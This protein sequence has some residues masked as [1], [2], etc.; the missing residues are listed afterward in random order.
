MVTLSLPAFRRLTKKKNLSKTGQAIFDARERFP[1]VSLAD[2]YDELT[3]P[4]DLRKAHQSNDKAVW[5]AYAKSLSPRRRTSLRR[6][7]DENLPAVNSKIQQIGE[8]ILMTV[9]RYTV[10]PQPVYKKSMVVSLMKH[11]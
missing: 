7:P 9:Q 11:N 4:S 10:T 6:L 1:E 2:I 3:K 5:E 8:N